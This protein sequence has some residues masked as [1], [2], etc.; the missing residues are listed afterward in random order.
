MRYHFIGM[1][2]T[3]VV[4]YI[5][6]YNMYLSS[7][8]K[9]LLCY[10]IDD[11]LEMRLEIVCD[12][13]S[14][15]LTSSSAM[16]SVPWGRIMYDQSVDFKSGHVPCF[17]KWN[18]DKSDVCHFWEEALGASS[19]L[20]NPFPSATRLT[21]FQTEVPSPWN[22]AATDERWARNTRDAKK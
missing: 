6:V 4:D 9:S 14:L 13:Q 15:S 2:I 17:V 3:R 11:R 19:Q 7:W 21:M 18:V 20:W 16:W 5:L 10:L 1:S 12:L 8:K 22:K